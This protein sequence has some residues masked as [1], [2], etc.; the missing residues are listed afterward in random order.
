VANRAQRRKAKKLARKRVAGRDARM[1]KVEPFDRFAPVRNQIR[2]LS[3]LGNEYAGVPM[4]IDGEELI[5]EPSYRF[6]SV[7]N[8]PAPEDNGLLAGEK[9][10]NTF[11]SHRYRHTVYVIERADGKVI[12]VMVPPVSR[13]MMELRTMGCSVAWGIEQEHNALNL[14]A[15]LLPHRKFKEYL[16]TGM[17]LES[18]KRSGVAYIFRKL[19]PTLALKATA[20]GEDMTILAALCMHPIAYYQDSWAGAMCPTDDVIAHLQMVRAD[21]HMFW[22]RA[23]QHSAHRPEAGL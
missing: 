10:R 9:I 6:A 1:D 11:W 13:A 17:I 15:T 22:R 12:K 4:P 18:S 23:N 19:R 16:L 2:E 3:A 21:E 8:K 14:L 7:F 20:N 5:V